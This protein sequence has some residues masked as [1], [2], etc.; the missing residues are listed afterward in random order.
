M[1]S[2]PAKQPRE[3]AKAQKSA[4]ETASLQNSLLKQDHSVTSVPKESP[5]PKMKENET[6]Q[7]TNW[8]VS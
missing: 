6:F 5:V 1:C 2:Q 3:V 4:K 7:T 8:K